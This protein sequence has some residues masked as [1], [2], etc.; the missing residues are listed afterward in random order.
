[1]RDLLVTAIIFGSLPFIL[2]RP[3]IGVLVWSW[4]SYMNPHRLTWGFA[5]DM[6]F[7]QIVAVAL[8][9]SIL[10]NK[11]IRKPPMYPVTWV[12][13]AF[14]AWMLLT[15]A[16]A[17]YPDRAFLEL[18]DVLKIQLIIFLTMM[19]MRTPERVNMMVWVIFLSI[20]FYGIKGGV[21]TLLSGGSYRVWGPAD[22]VI[23][24]NNQL[25]VALLIIIP[26][27]YYLFQQTKQV[28]VRRGLLVSMLLIAVSAIGSQ[29]RGAFLAILAVGL[30]LWWKSRSKLAI[31][32]A[33]FAALPLVFVAMPQS[34]HERMSTIETYQEDASA[35][36]R[37]N[38]WGYAINLANDRAT[39][40]G[41]NSWSRQTYN[42]WAP[43]PNVMKAYV[44]HSIYF[45]VL[46]DHG[47]IGLLCFL[48]IFFGVWRTNT[49]IMRATAGDPEHQWMSDLARMIQVSLV[50]YAVGGAFL[51][52]SYFDLPWH[53][54]AI[55]LIMRAILEERGGSLEPAPRLEPAAGTGTR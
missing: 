17:I 46:A 22:S 20:G 19:I 38:A 33:V 13:F 39:G 48:T 2:A 52:L 31:G 24:D 8:L 35:T 9:V 34:W 47:W 30:F 5:Y 12:W 15:T 41:F 55:T 54:A 10:F 51:S 26:L 3:Y 53:I 21:F 11:D 23:S 44:A 1:M 18:I 37:L 28:W 29:S 45:H 43:D 36:S 6:P 14:I 49:R 25:A 7:A 50:A 32:I 42:I 27:G 40:G 4:L 16:L